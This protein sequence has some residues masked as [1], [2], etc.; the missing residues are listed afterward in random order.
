MEGMPIYDAG[1][2]HRAGFGAV[3]FGGDDKLIVWFVDKPMLNGVASKE[4]NRPI[5]QNVAHVHIQ[6]PG[7]RDYLEQ[8]ATQEHVARFPRQW[9]THQKKQASKIDGTPLAVLFPTDPALV[10]TMEN[11]NIFTVEQLGSLNDTAIQNIG[12]GGREFVTRA[13]SF[14]EAADKGKGFNELSARLDQLALQN[15]EKDAR[16]AALETALANAGEELPSA[17]RG[18]GR[19]R[20]EAA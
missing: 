9:E 10:K 14:L 6:Q 8:P 19:P 1:Q 16:I 12:M 13:K 15:T 11:I 4:A 17:K 20:K 18:P 3:S 2:V 7:E 5:Y